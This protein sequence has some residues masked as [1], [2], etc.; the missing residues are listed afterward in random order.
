MF[1][2]YNYLYQNHRN[3][4]TEKPV[5]TVEATNLITQFKTENNVASKKYLNTVIEV[6]GVVTE[7]E[8]DGIVI[9]DNVY[10]QFTDKNVKGIV[11]NH[12][13]T[14]KGRCIGFDELLE[15]VKIDQS[16]LIN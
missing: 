3:I 12:K 5:F 6:T 2:T 13:I 11:E 7:I 15:T 8:T 4:G 10:V 1:I 16:I 14:I 9:A